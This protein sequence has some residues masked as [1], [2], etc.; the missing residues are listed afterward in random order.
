MQLTQAAQNAARK[1]IKRIGYHAHVVDLPKGYTLNFFDKNPIITESPLE[2]F[3][4][5]LPDPS[6]ETPQTEV[7]QKFTRAFAHKFE[8]MVLVEG[9]NLKGETLECPVCHKE[10]TTLV[11]KIRFAGLFDAGETSEPSVF[12]KV[13]P[14]CG[15][16]NGMCKGVLET[17]IRERRSSEEVSV[18]C[19][20]IESY[21]LG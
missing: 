15:E 9:A 6:Q 2:E 8:A 10:A 11:H 1:P 21:A 18:M 7:L 19:I 13:A 20:A 4:T 12:D 3:H 16:K 5:H 17:L 14:W